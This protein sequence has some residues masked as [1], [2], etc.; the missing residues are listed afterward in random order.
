MQLA[1]YLEEEGFKVDQFIGDN[2][3]FEK[4]ISEYQNL[5]VRIFNES[6]QILSVEYEQ[7]ERFD[8]EYS[9]IM[10][11]TIINLHQLKHLIESFK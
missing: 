11:D 8:S 5:Y 2:M 6:D 7:L 1:K 9:K 3:L 10:F 4:H